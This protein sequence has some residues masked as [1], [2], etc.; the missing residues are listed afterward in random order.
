MEGV[1]DAPEAEACRR[2]QHPLSRKR[3]H[4][5]LLQMPASWMTGGAVRCQS[6]SHISSGYLQTIVHMI[7][8]NATT[9]HSEVSACITAADEEAFDTAVPANSWAVSD[10]VVLMQ[11]GAS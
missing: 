11:W 9:C 7:K 8:Q 10:S 4:R 2:Q 5:Q 3:L 6:A 1:L